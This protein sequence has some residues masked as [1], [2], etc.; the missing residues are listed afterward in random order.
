[1]ANVRLHDRLKERPID[2]FTREMST[3]RPLPLVAYNTDEL[4]TTQVRPLARVEFDSNRAN[5]KTCAHVG[6]ADMG[7]RLGAGWLAQQVP[8]FCG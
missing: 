4:V 8:T 1:M 3:L 6:Q 2:R 7:R 5:F